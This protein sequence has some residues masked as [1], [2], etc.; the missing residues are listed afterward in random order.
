MGLKPVRPET[1]I[2]IFYKRLASDPAMLAPHVF[3]DNMGSTIS[4]PRD[5]VVPVSE[6]PVAPENRGPE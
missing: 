5:I 2:P 4:D 6:L 1:F 3:P